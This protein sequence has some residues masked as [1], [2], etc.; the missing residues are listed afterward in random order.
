MNSLILLID[1]PQKYINVLG[2]PFGKTAHLKMVWY[3]AV[4]AVFRCVILCAAA[5]ANPGD[6]FKCVVWL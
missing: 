3:C 4:A 2:N 6:N 1:M 5:A